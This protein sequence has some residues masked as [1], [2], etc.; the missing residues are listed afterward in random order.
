MR[1]RESEIGPVK[2]PTA[3]EDHARAMAGESAAAWTDDRLNILTAAVL[4]L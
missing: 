3:T 4:D 2:V 1:V